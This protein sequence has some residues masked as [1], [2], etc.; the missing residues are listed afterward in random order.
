MSYPPPAVH[1]LPRLFLGV[2]PM[3]TASARCVGVGV[4]LKVQ[5]L[6]A[7]SPPA[8]VGPAPTRFFADHQS[9]LNRA[10]RCSA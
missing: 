8:I 9:R 10:V 5:C 2:E 6:L 4:P 3:G 7:A 1:S